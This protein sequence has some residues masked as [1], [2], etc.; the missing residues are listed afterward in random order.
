MI[1]I[2]VLAVF[3]A[4]TTAQEFNITSFD[5][6]TGFFFENMGPIKYVTDNFKLVIYAN[7]TSYEDRFNEINRYFN[8]RHKLFM[9]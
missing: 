9:S 8:E 7:I 1:A 3:S 2:C 6:Q 4:S 5:N